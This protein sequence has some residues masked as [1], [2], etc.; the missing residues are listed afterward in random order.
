MPSGSRTARGRGAACGIEDLAHPFE[1][2][3]E[4]QK[5]LRGRSGEVFALRPEA[6]ARPGTA[7]NL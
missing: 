6:A 2:P 1:L 7:L 5:R 4:G 3:G